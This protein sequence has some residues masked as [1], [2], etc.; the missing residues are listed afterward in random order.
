MMMPIGCL[1]K[2]LLNINFLIVFLILLMCPRAFAEEI[3]IVSAA[4]MQFALE[5]LQGQFESDHPDVKLRM[6]FGSSGKLAAQIENGA[7][8]D[9]FL[10]ADMDYPQ[11]LYKKGFTLG[12]PKVYAYGALVLWTLN[13]LDLSEGMKLLASGAIKKIALAN[14]RT[15]PYGAQAVKAMKTAGLYEDLQKKLV[16][17]ESIGQVNGFISSHNADIGFT[18]KSSLYGNAKI[19]GTWQEVDPRLYE[20]I[21]Q[22]AVILRYA[23]KQNLSAAQQFFEHLFSGQARDIFKK[24]GYQ[25][26]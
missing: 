24:Y 12:P 23:G 3:T 13:D 19:T 2:L 7:P 26:P 18:A 22:G 11:A 20:S 6:I 16:Y 4:N 9:I 1:V 5:A 8:F 21:A 15:A 10:S 25:L 14:P 17:A